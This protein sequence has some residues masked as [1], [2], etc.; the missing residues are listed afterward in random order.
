ME[1]IMHLNNEQDDVAIDL[2][3]VVDETKGAQTG[4]QSDQLGGMRQGFGLSD[5]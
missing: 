2:G 1:A 3:S 4:N 5:D